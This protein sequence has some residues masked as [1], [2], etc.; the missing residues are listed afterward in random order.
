LPGLVALVLE[1]PPS[2]AD[3]APQI[4]ADAY[5]AADLLMALAAADPFLWSIAHQQFLAFQQ[6]NPQTV[7]LL[8]V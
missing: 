6:E 8:L 5:A 7:R 3:S 2:P 1:L 4:S